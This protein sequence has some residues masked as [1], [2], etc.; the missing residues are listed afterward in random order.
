MEDV[1]KV[2]HKDGKDIRRYL[3]IAYA[4]VVLVMINF[5]IRPSD[6]AVYGWLFNGVSDAKSW[7]ITKVFLPVLF[8]LHILDLLPNFM[9]LISLQHKA[10]AEKAGH[11]YDVQAREQ[12]EHQYGPDGRDGDPWD[13]TD[14]EGD[15]D[16]FDKHIAKEKRY[17]FLNDLF[18]YVAGRMYR[19][20]LSLVLGVAALLVLYRTDT[21]PTATPEA[22]VGARQSVSAGT[23]TFS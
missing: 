9:G 10:K 13:G 17:S 6:I 20:G 23:S 15:R 7:G 2:V 1:G 12:Y 8:M 5:E 22:K 18:L 4:T 11:Y 14:F 21:L 3:L 16:A 19:V